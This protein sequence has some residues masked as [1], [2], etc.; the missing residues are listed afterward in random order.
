MIEEDHHFRA[1]LKRIIEKESQKN[2]TNDKKDEVQ[3]EQ[4]E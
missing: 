2:P 1:R 4:G 3:Y